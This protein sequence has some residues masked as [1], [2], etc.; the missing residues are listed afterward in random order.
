MN[1]EAETFYG[2]YPWEERAPLALI[3]HSSIRSRFW[4]MFMCWGGLLL[5]QPYSFSS[6]RI[7]GIR[8]FHIYRLVFQ[9]HVWPNLVLQ[10]SHDM[11]NLNSMLPPSVTKIL[12]DAANKQ[13]LFEGVLGR[14]I[15]LQEALGQQHSREKQE[16]LHIYLDT[17]W[18]GLLE[19]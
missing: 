17:S 18:G 5:K 8:T 11:K 12:T 3:F 15:K 2:N 9:R 10:I 14:I 1:N 6:I 19:K 13:K 16:E 4:F 7:H